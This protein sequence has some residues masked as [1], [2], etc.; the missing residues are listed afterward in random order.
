MTNRETSTLKSEPAV[1]QEGFTLMKYTGQYVAP[2]GLYL[3]KYQGW[4]GQEPINVANEDV[5]RLEAT[6]FWQ[7]HVTQPAAKAKV[8]GASVAS[9]AEPEADEDEDTSRRKGARRA[10]ADK[11]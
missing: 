3:G 4:K 11:E 10:R 1:Q 5:A 9:E 6:G 7:K 8:V 2:T